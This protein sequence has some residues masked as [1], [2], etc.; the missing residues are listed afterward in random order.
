MSDG[1]GVLVEQIL[2][3]HVSINSFYGIKYAKAPVG[4]PRWRALLPIDYGLYANSTYI[5]GTVFG[6]A[7]IQSNPTWSQPSSVDNTL[8][9]RE[10]C[11]SLN[12]L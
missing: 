9:Q 4:N 2:S 1:F 12:T 3:D 8:S 11:L 7:C 10:N 5:N 6:D